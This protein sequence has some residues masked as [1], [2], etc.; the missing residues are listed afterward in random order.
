MCLAYPPRV[1]KIQEVYRT[2][3]QGP[4]CEP[5]VLPVEF[6]SL[7]DV[8][9]LEQEEPSQRNKQIAEMR[10]VALTFR[11]THLMQKLESKCAGAEA[12]FQALLEQAEIRVNVVVDDKRQVPWNIKLLLN[13]QLS[14]PGP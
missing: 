9:T 14:V 3:I 4:H 12:L 10:L 11:S 6:F 2:D 5:F 13:P 7:R 8:A 1:F